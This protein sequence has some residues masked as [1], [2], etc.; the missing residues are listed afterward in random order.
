M[1]I[2][3]YKSLSWDCQWEFHFPVQPL[4]CLSVI[5][6]VWMELLWRINCNKWSSVL[7]AEAWLHLRMCQGGE[8]QPSVGASRKSKKP[9]LSRD[10]GHAGSQP[11]VQNNIPA[12][13][14]TLWPQGRDRINVSV[15]A[16]G[17]GLTA[18]EL[19]LF[20]QSL[21]LSLGWRL[22]QRKS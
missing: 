5:H 12:A 19:L 10:P 2:F 17:Q 1:L 16:R 20:S 21:F 14:G 6:Q 15:T 3:L 9:E 13:P 8:L 4:K 7:A 18:P 22:V 11:N